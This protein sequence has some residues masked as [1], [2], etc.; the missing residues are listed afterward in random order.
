MSTK[1]K[2]THGG[3]RKGAGAP[4]KPPVLLTVPDTS[5]PVQFMLSVM[6]DTTADA[7]LRVDAAR[8]LLPYLH[9]KAVE[10]GK[11]GAAADAA[12]KAGSGKFAPGK[13]PTLATVTNLP[14]KG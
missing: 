9:S 14:H 2:V 10:P 5:D 11:K 12:K 3:V 6:R 1:T 13:P 4:K 8:G 7:R